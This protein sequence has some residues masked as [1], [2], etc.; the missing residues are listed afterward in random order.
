MKN[1]IKHEIEGMGS[2][3]SLDSPLKAASGELQTSTY[4]W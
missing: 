2:V 4:E 1:G 3:C